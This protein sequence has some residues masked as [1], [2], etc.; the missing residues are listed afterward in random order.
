MHR[1]GPGLSGKIVQRNPLG[2]GFKFFYICFWRIAGK[3]LDHHIGPMFTGHAM[4]LPL[5]L[6][7]IPGQHGH[8]GD[9][10]WAA[11]FIQDIEPI[12]HQNYV[13]DTEVF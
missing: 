10:L 9:A 11:Q 12:N 13:T 6:G 5:F 3:G 8:P 7:N 1:I 2:L 4:P